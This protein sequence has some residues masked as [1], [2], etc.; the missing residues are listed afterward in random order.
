MVLTRYI[1][2]KGDCRGA[3]WVL[4]ARSLLVVIPEAGL[5]RTFMAAL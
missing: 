4:A 2:F 3:D 5:L 1:S